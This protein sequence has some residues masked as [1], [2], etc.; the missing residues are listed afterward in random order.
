[1]DKNHVDLTNNSR[2]PRV[3]FGVNGIG[4]GHIKRSLHIA[5][6]LTK[7]GIELSFST[8]NDP[9]LINLIQLDGFHVAKVPPI[10]WVDRKDGT[11]DVKRSIVRFPL[12]VITLIK[13]IV[14]EVRHL[15]QFEPDLVVSDARFSTIVAAKI[16]RRPVILLN[17][18]YRVPLPKKGAMW[19]RIRPLKEA[20][21]TFLNFIL[22]FLWQ[23]ANCHLVP[24]L[25]PPCFL[26]TETLHLPAS[27][28]GR[29]RFIGAIMPAN[30]QY[31]NQN[32]QKGD[33]RPHVFVV[34]GGTAFARK[35]MTQVVHEIVSALPDFNFTITL[36]DPSRRNYEKR[37]EEGAR[38]VEL[39]GWIDDPHMYYQ[40]C[41]VIIARPGHNTV[42]EALLHGKPMLLLP[43]K[44]HLEYISIAKKIEEMGIGIQLL[45]GKI[46]IE[47]VKTALQILLSP[48]CKTRSKR[49]G[50]WARKYNGRN[51][52]VC[53]ILRYIT[54]LKQFKR[55]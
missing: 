17:H 19:G 5:H 50:I 42:T 22:F 39:F 11:I 38:I 34:I 20:Y 12:I 16:L 40:K 49:L 41:D 35:Q 31:S 52:V 46:S 27:F 3:Y 29:L 21:E 54:T 32:A 28:L 37:E 45:E 55:R 51:I 36:G 4:A 48:K 26:A 1:M 43:I 14:A 13:Q 33:G 47:K 44:N 2:P 53:E 6:E 10:V 9:A 23:R 30:P 25:P 7:K 18:V 24:D 8:Y 15:L